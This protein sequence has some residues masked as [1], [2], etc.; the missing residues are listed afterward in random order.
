MSWI[1]LQQ[2]RKKSQSGRDNRGVIL[3]QFKARSQSGCQ[4]VWYIWLILDPCSAEE[5]YLR[6]SPLADTQ[7]SAKEWELSLASDAYS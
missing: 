3:G 2:E 4:Q 1:E 5:E 6:L 7:S